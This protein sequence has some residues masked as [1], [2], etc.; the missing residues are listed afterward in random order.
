MLLPACFCVFSL[1]DGMSGE[2]ICLCMMRSF[3]LGRFQFLC[4]REDVLVFLE[5]FV[6]SHDWTNFCIGP[7]RF[8]DDVDSICCFGGAGC[9]LFVRLRS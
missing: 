2:A 8:E 9:C 4:F 5:W 1:S 7:T 3:F 6:L